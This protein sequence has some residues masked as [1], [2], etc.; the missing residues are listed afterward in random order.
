MPT[1]NITQSQS[2]PPMSSSGWRLA[3]FTSTLT[4][5]SDVPLAP[6]A[7]CTSGADSANVKVP[8]GTDATKCKYEGI[9]RRTAG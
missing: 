4:A 8:H 2:K 5:P 7:S 3:P 9:I 1:V 6:S